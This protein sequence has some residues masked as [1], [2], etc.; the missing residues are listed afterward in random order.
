MNKQFFIVNALVKNEEGK[1]L[2]VRR[3]R[4]WHKE[5][6]NRWELPGGKVDFGEEP[7]ETAVRET[8][9][10]TGYQIEI[11]KLI[12]KILTGTWNYGDKK[13][14]QILIC[15]EAR[16]KGGEKSIEDHGVNK[17]EWFKPEEIEELDC[18]PGTKEFLEKTET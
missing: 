10:E 2:L 14:Q 6:H 17:I 3:D 9:E 12:P 1:I 5:A 18:L 4:E 8:K 15:Y 16:L 11:E 7:I 13:S